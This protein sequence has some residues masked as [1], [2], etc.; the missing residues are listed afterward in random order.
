[1]PTRSLARPVVLL[2]SYG[3]RHAHFRQGAFEPARPPARADHDFGRP[4]V[5]VPQKVRALKRFKALAAAGAVVFAG[6]V[7]Y[8]VSL[9][10]R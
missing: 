10:F 4:E 9:L 1:M 8:L 5:F 6:G 7:V 3:W 2:L